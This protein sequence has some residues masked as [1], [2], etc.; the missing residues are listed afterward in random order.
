MKPVIKPAGWDVF[1]FNAAEV[2]PNA[3][4]VDIVGQLIKKF[5]WQFDHPDV[6]KARRHLFNFE[7]TRLVVQQISVPFKRPLYIF[8]LQG[9]S[10]TSTPQQVCARLGRPMVEM[11]VSP[12]TVISDFIGGWILNEDGKMELQ[13][14]PLANAMLY[15]LVLVI[16]ELDRL[17]PDVQKALNGVLEGRDLVIPQ[18]SE[19]IAPHPN[20]S[21]ILTANTNNQYGSQ[22]F[23]SQAGDASVNDRP[24]FIEVGYMQEEQ[25]I[26]VLGWYLE[27]Y[28]GELGFPQ[29]AISMLSTEIAPSINIMVKVAND[30]RHSFKTGTSGQGGG[31][32][33]PLSLRS[34]QIWLEQLIWDSAWE[35][36]ALKAAYEKAYVLSLPEVDRDA[37]RNV[38]RARLPAAA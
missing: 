10:K 23:L 32:P 34:L 6:P 15:G 8:G 17:P 19:R 21:V 2:K 27:D 7:L 35:G 9:T 24:L 33:A 20:F 16:D 18:T 36:S 25:E 5:E 22:G 12:E 30:T 31:L 28:L 13:Y 14:G 38:L 37:A 26:K 1:G 29:E 11:V 4:S 3:A